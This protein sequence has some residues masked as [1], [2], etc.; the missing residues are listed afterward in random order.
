M[1]RKILRWLLAILLPFALLIG[2]ILIFPKIEAQQELKP[3]TRTP[4]RQIDSLFYAQRFV[5]YKKEF[6]KKK[7]LLPGFELQTLLALSYYPE[8][9]DV[10]IQFIYKKAWIPLSS[11]PYLPS[12]FQKRDKWI[13]RIIVSSESAAGMEPI[14]LKNLPFNAQVGILAHELGHTLHYQ[15]YGFWQMLK[16][17]LLYAFDADFRATHERSTDEQVVYHSLGWQLFDYAKFVRTDPSTVAGYESSKDF[18]DKYYLTPA[19]VMEVMNQVP[20][21]G[22]APVTTPPPPY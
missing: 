21:Y 4:I 1:L 17:A 10:E 20:N 14:L 18:L 3:S 8:L 22:A 6:G 11:R 13:Y 9:R 5:D 16:F 19:N 2:A 7:V 15:K 12:M